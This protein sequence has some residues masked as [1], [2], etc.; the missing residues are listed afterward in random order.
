MRSCQY[1]Q[2]S[3]DHISYDVMSKILGTTLLRT[4]CNLVTCLHWLSGRHHRV[5]SWANDVM[6]LMPIKPMLK[7]GFCGPSPFLHFKFWNVMLIYLIR[8]LPNL[9]L[10][11]LL[12]SKIMVASVYCLPFLRYMCCEYQCYVEYHSISFA[13]NTRARS[14]T[15]CKL[16]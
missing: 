9:G 12:F 6:Q 14:T 13:Q 11:R 1:R 16:I 7:P 5:T 15:K 8:D 10:S 3:L 4:E 2:E